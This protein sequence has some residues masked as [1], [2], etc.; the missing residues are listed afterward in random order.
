MKRSIKKI[1]EEEIELAKIKIWSRIEKIFEH[2]HQTS[3]QNSLTL[4]FKNKV[5][6]EILTGEEI[7]GESNTSI[8]L[9]L[10]DDSTGNVVDSEPQASA[11]VEIV[12][13]KGESESVSDF[14]ENIIPEIE[15]KKPLLAGKVR[16]KLQGGVGYVENVKLR[17]HTSKIKPSIFRLGARI[18]G[19]FDGVRINEAKTESFIVKDFRNKYY[20]KHEKP[21]LSDEVSR[22]VNIRKG[23]KIDKRLQVGKIFNVEDLLIRLLIDPQGLK[24]IVKVGTKK[25]D[26]TVKNARACK[27]DE[28]VH[29][30]ISIEQKIGVVFNLLGQV[31]GLYTKSQYV[32]TTMLSENDK[33]AA[34]ELLASA[35]EHW[36][37]VQPF[38]D[39]NSLEQYLTG[40]SS[41]IDLPNYV[42]P[43]NRGYENMIEAIG[44]SSS[45]FS[46]FSFQSTSSRMNSISVEDFDSFSTDDVDIIYAQLSPFDPATIFHDFDDF[47]EQCEYVDEHTNGH[48]NGS[49]G[50]K[51]IFYDSRDVPF[52]EPRVVGE[53]STQTRRWRKLLCVSRLCSFKNRDGIKIRKKRKV[54]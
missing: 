41:Y 17:H 38:D 47:L 30:Y 20:K 37:N 32:S 46:S 21:S 10:V 48:V 26:A 45:R 11:I 52:V 44:E 28:R 4:Q 2:D 5:S 16:L 27:I 51:H 39:I 33:A 42:D 53:I 49:N 19:E 3:S 25:W 31:L 35:Y 43:N 36:E 1:V 7:K 9:N 14:K 23:G 50:D 13:L 29:F 40:L 15:G 6:Q 22:L 34:Q 24:S 18:V 12:L 8:E 54:G